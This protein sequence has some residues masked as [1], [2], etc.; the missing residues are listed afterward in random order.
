M[1]SPRH[2]SGARSGIARLT[3]AASPDSRC[4]LPAS[5]GS[6][7]GGGP[8]RQYCGNGM[9]REGEN[10]ESLLPSRN[11]EP[12]AGS[13]QRRQGGAC[14]LPGAVSGGCARRSTAQGGL[15]QRLARHAV[16]PECCHDLRRVVL[17]APQLLD[18]PFGLGS[19]GRGLAP[20]LVARLQRRGV[21]QANR[22]VPGAGRQRRAVGAEGQRP[23]EALC[24]RAAAPPP[25]PA[26]GPTARPP[27]RGRPWPGA[28]RRGGRRRRRPRRCVRAAPGT[29]RRR[30]ATGER[31]GPDCTRRGGGC[32]D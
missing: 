18:Q 12:G 24:A 20:G 23:D 30:S 7:S 25:R 19:Q 3:F 27:R 8:P 1:R 9:T 32:R 10:D 15:A 14:G 17:L 6:T 13:W 29:R 21:P 26:P 4:P 22:A 16:G 31:C 5:V 11:G 2:P 28:C